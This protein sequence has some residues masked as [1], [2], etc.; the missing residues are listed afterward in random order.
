MKLIKQVYDDFKKLCSP[1]VFYLIISLFA[2]LA[3]II[4]NY[5]NNDKFCLGYYECNVSNT[6]TIYVMKI[7]YILFW[8]WILN[9]MCKGGYKKVAWF[10]VLLPFILFFVIL[11]LYILV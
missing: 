8:A 6:N 11:G 1:A 4:Q 2:L 9:L 5:G 10:F 7:F 3:M